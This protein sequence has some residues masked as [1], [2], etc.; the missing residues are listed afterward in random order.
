MEYCAIC[1]KPNAEIHHL[2]FGVANRRLAD[3]DN[4]VLPLC[5]EHHEFLHKNARVS[6]IIGQ[7]MFE[8][9]YLIEQMILPFDDSHDEISDNARNAFRS[10][11]GRS[12]L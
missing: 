3:A 2:V 7:L 10:R 8:R 1:D 12:Y 4:L 9:E 6:K 11:Y 5:R